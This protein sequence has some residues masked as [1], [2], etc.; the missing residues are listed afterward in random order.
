MGLM[1]QA[2]ADIKRITGDLVGF[3]QSMTFVSADGTKTATINGLHAKI[4]M[5]TDTDG[6]TV[7]SKKAH[8]S[9]SESALTDQGYTTRNSKDEC[10]LK[11]HKV[12]VVDSTGVSWQYI[13]R[14]VF[15]DEAVGLI[16]CFFND[17]E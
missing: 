5:A 8:V 17:F 1:E 14:E 7:N 6:N 15:P 12:T 2:Q 13:I 4:H 11:G 3:A 16:V 10:S 9:I